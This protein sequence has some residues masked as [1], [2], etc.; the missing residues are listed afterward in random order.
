M[1]I[2]AH[3]SE[4]AGFPI[5][6]YEHGGG[7]QN[8]GSSAWLLT[9]GDDAYEPK[10]PLANVIELFAS[11]PG[12]DKVPAL[13]VGAWEEMHDPGGAEKNVTALV[14]GAGRLAALK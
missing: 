12:V 14:R 2:S 3:E 4:F 5:R 13:V 6:E 10:Y 8:P 1:T 7:L 11:E 9:L